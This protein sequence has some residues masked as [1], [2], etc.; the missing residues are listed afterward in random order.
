M[1]DTLGL[2]NDLIRFVLAF[3]QPSCVKLILGAGSNL[4]PIALVILIPLFDLV[5]Y[6]GLR[7]F[8]ITVSPIKRVSEILDESRAPS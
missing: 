6:P 1:L 8:G 3:S 5:I 7:K 2:P 4:N